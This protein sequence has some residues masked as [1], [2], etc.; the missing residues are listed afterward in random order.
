MHF[1][2]HSLP[3]FDRIIIPP[4][5]TLP[6][7]RVSAELRLPPVLTYSDDVLYNWRLNSTSNP[8]TLPTPSNLRCNTSFTSTNDEAEFYLVPARM[9]LVGVEAL[10]IMRSTMDE[11][12]VSDD[13]AVRR[14]T[15]Y[16]YQLVDVIQQLR[17]VLLDVKRGCDPQVFYHEIRPWFRGEDSQRGEKWIFD[18]IDQD[19]A[20]LP[21]TEL[22]GPS[23][24]QSS[25]IHALDIFLGVDK[26]SHETDMTGNDA[27]ALEVSQ[28]HKSTFLKRM[29]LYMP[30]HHRAFL[31]HLSNTPRPLRDFVFSA[32]SASPSTSDLFSLS[33]K[34]NPSGKGSDGTNGMALLEA[35][36]ATVMALKELRDAHMI[37]VALYIIGPA[38]HAQHEMSHLSSNNLATASNSGPGIDSD[39]VRKVGEEVSGENGTLKGTGGTDLVRFLKGV[40]DQTHGALMSL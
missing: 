5:L 1:Y 20:L 23:A 3:P 32:A 9:E 2:I 21:P 29:R 19:P 10:D 39:F 38:R 22:S 16:L 6:L 18:G 34:I 26:Y 17:T 37:I 27:E 15:E 14:I 25:L 24:G 40:R 28:K 12:F 30:R 8:D 31:D 36:N 35:Y 7:L 33:S 4:P 13:I 11:L